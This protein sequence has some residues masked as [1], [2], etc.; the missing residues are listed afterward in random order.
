[1]L[2]SRVRVFKE[3]VHFDRI[4]RP[5]NCRGRTVVGATLRS[6]RD[7]RA[8][9]IA[10]TIR[11]I[12]TIATTTKSYGR[13]HHKEELVQDVGG[14]QAIADHQ[15]YIA[16]LRYGVYGKDLW[17]SYSAHVLGHI[18]PPRRQTGSAIRLLAG[19]SWIP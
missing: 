11:C 18:Q 10:R 13:W 19:A 9:D 4:Q 5:K 14:R 1:M 17:R 6:Q 7:T 3:G 12:R 16:V 8:E 15:V 2:T